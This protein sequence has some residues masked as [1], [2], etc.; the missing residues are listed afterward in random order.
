MGE[1]DP[2]AT[3]RAYG[4]LAQEVMDAGVAGV[5][6]MR[7]NV[8]V[9]TAAQ[10]VADL[11]GA[12]AQGQSLGQAVTLGRKQLASQPMREI[13][14]DPIPL[15]DW[16]VPVVYEA[17]PITLFPP[18]GAGLAPAQSGRP[19]GSPLRITVDAGTRTEGQS[20]LPTPDVG[21]FGR[22]ETLLALDRAFDTQRLVLLHAYAGDGK[23][24]TAAEFARWYTQTGGLDGPVLFTS[25]E[26]YR[27]LPRVLDEIG[28][29]F[30]ADLERANVN[31][32]ALD[33]DER[34]AVALQVLKQTPALWIWDNVEPVAGFPTGTPSAWSA[35]EQK[36]LKDF[37][38]DA[39]ETRARFVLT[40]RR[41]ERGWLGDLPRRV[42]L[43][44][45]PMQER[46][47]LARAL[48]EKH[49]RRLTEVE[50]WRPLLAFTQGNPLTITVLVGQALREEKKTKKEI[51]EF[52]TKLRAGEATF[53]DEASEGRSRSLGASL[54]YGFASAFTEDERKILALLHFFQGFVD[55]DALR[56]MG[57][58]EIG[59]L[60]E[61]RG[62][63]RDVGIA[64]LDRAAEIGL[65]TAHGGGYYGIHPALPWYFRNLFEQYY[66]VISQQSSV[67]SETNDRSLFTD[68]LRATR[69][70]V[71]ALGTLG[72]HYF[73]QYEGG[74]RDVISALAAEEA[75]LLHAR[76]L[77]RTNGWWGAVI[78][79]MQ[80]LRQLYAHTGRRAEW[81]RLVNEIVP[82]F[83]DPATDGPR[84]G[85]EDNWSLVTEYRV[86]LAEEARQWTE[87]ER[88]QRVCVEWDRRRAAP[89]LALPPE[90]LDRAQRNAIRTLTV[91]LHG[92]GEIQ[93]ELGQSE[94]VT[95]YEESLVLSERIG[96]RAGAA[97]CA[98]NLGH[99][100]KDIPAL[101]DLAQ[102]E[103]WYRRSLEL[104]DERDRLGRGKCLSQLGYV[105]YERFKDA[106]AANA[107]EPELL[108][109]L[110]E[111]LNYY[112]Q[113]LD[114]DP[115][116]APGELATD[117]NQ[118][119]LIYYDAGDLDR[120]L[121]H[122]R[123]SIRYEE[124]QGNLYGAGTT[125]FNVALALAKASRL[126]DAREYAHAALR[127]F[128]TYGEGAAEEIQKT[129]RLIEKI[130]SLGH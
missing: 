73:R 60:P 44:P 110:N 82:D 32:L 119:G 75:N 52:V 111:A 46:V 116:D 14:Y 99:A 91:S 6:A 2:H 72:H 43:P 129:R 125:R 56:A 47:Q 124:M 76:Q 96:E 21:F 65:L 95:A 61:V 118:L 84:P 83:V 49:G 7:Y 85:R 77:A 51:E 106:R 126:A 62:L 63:T 71:E 1:Q 108:K 74:N 19:Q 101:R 113:A 79:A 31:W 26:Q 69:A 107:P 15:Q 8:Y 86:L 20:A 29:V 80:G 68:H 40:S 98:F 92:L 54:S 90:S 89:A 34:R 12:L 120:A 17:A 38:S 5:V 28:R 55:V 9:V 36:A 114:L 50:D 13:A 123:E 25:F 27:P 103:H 24:T 30:G 59:N 58:P 105:A 112:H 11:Y 35:A 64:L 39:R 41:D 33:D 23:T 97:S 37:L 22:D 93:R 87:A 16:P 100:Y 117:H 128:E 109:H 67:N 66:P 104:F 18:V 48:A 130:E 78:G 127:N 45:M 53:D 115:P 4:S 10:F 57:N 81:A 102:A 94:C 42:T 121:H 3:V 122:Y 70:F 88:L